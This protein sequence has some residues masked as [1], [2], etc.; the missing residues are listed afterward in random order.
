MPQ[1]K[2]LYDKDL[3]FGQADQN[4]PLIKIEEEKKKIIPKA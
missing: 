4:K 1:P 3:G 2:H